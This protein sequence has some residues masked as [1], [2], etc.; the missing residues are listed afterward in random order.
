MNNKTYIAIDLKSFY[1][2]VEAMERGLDPMTTN[3]VVADMSRTEKTIC[4]AVSPSLK[5]YGISGRARMFEAIQQ[6]KIANADRLRRAP[7]RKFTGSSYDDNELKA[8]PNLSIDYVVAT[9]RMALYIEYSTR[10]Y[11]VYLKYVAP[12]DIHVYSIDEVFIDLTDYVKIYKKTAQ[13]VAKMLIDRVYELTG[14]CATVGIGTNLFLAKL[15]LDITAKKSKDYMG[16]LDEEIFKKDIKSRCVIRKKET[17][18]LVMNY[19][20]NN[21]GCTTSINNILENLNKS[22]L[23]ISKTTLLRYIKCLI[24]AKIL[25]ECDRFDMK[26]KRALL[27]EKKYYIADLSFS[28]ISNPDSRINYGPV[29]ENIIYTYARSKS[30]TV[31]VGRIGKLECDFILKDKELNYSYVQVAYTILE[32]KKTEDREYNS[33]EMIRDNY[34]KYV[35]SLDEFD[36]SRDGVKHKNI[37]E[38]LVTKEWN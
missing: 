19:I 4:L 16:Y 35:V 15:A 33:L 20:I 23:G 25:Y 14:L 26:S 2:S 11:D 34:P 31:T 13:Q 10:I 28:Y 24:D 36:M 21:F 32:S 3:L 12:E 5:A 30:Y 6:V 17:F 29:L 27:G 7:G 37:K 1:A 8:N 38:F 22:G 9:P 18:D